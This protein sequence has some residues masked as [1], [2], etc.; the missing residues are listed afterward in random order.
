MN[1]LLC[2]LGLA[3]GHRFQTETVSATLCF[4]IAPFVQKMGRSE[5][6]LRTR[7]IVHAP[8]KRARLVR[9]TRCEHKLQPSEGGKLARESKAMERIH[10]SDNTDK[11]RFR[12][13]L[14]I[15]LSTRVA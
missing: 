14:N 15:A 13:T 11:N 8:H 10:L 4:C 1:F 6:L 3:T 9:I 12:A 7:K 2:S 5:L